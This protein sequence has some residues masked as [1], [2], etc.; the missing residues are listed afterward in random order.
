MFELFLDGLAARRAAAA[1]P[2]AAGPSGVAADSVAAGPSGVAADSVFQPVGA[3]SPGSAVSEGDV[4]LEH[5]VAERQ[6]IGARLAASLSP[7]QAGPPASVAQRPRGLAVPSADV[8]AALD[9]VVR[10]GGAG[11][12]MARELL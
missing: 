1:A 10:T 7:N 12:R 4:P 6:S 2:D 11:S 5:F 8:A 3:A 9:A